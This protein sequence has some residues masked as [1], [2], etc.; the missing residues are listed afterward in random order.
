MRLEVGCM[1]SALNMIHDQADKNFI[2][3]CRVWLLKS[4]LVDYTGAT[5]DPLSIAAS[6]LTVVGAA[7]KVLAR[8]QGYQRCTRRPQ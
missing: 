8:A 4:C 3:V 1:T 2:L 7:H 6:V 5:A